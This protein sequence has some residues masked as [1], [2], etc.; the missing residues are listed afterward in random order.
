[1][2]IEFTRALLRNR[3]VIRCDGSQSRPVSR[4]DVNAVLR[5][6]ESI[7]SSGLV[8][9]DGLD[10][11]GADLRGLNL[12]GCSFE[13]CNLS[14]VVA[15]PLV[16]ILGRELPVGDPGVNAVINRWVRGEDEQF[17]QED[18]KVRPTSWKTRS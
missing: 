10:L 7:P 4:A 16:T 18:I 13:G 12:K 15:H 5:F 14:H 11:S 9:F 2:A 6:L 3:A 17:E 1:M 8:R